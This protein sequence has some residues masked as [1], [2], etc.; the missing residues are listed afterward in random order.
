MIY[1]DEKREK[2]YQHLKEDSYKLEQHLQDRINNHHQHLSDL[3]EILRISKNMLKDLEIAYTSGY[4]SD[5]TYEVFKYLLIQI[6]DLIHN[7][8]KQT[9]IAPKILNE[10]R[11]ISEIAL[12]EI[13]PKY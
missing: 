9:S 12:G 4:L 6:L 7:F 3:K 8:N 13:K 11:K 1:D 2:I 5:E 10:I